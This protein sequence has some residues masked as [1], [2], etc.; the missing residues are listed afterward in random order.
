MKIFACL[1]CIMWV[2]VTCLSIFTDAA[3]D[4][5]QCIKNF[6]ECRSSVGYNPPSCKEWIKC[7]EFLDSWVR[8]KSAK[9]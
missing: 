4:S 5:A 8:A 1:V 3:T 2:M 7:R 6:Q 9:L